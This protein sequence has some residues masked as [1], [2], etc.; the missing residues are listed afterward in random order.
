[1]KQRQSKVSKWRLYQ[2]RRPRCENSGTISHRIIAGKQF[3]IRFLPLNPDFVREPL[4]RVRKQP[5]LLLLRW[6]IIVNIEVHGRHSERCHHL[7]AGWNDCCMLR[8]ARSPTTLVRYP[9]Y[10]WQVNVPSSREKEGT[11]PCSVDRRLAKTPR[12]YSEFVLTP[13][14]LKFS[15]RRA[16]TKRLITRRGGFCADASV[17]GSVNRRSRQRG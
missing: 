11:A 12:R 10:V 1:M 2:H 16:T 15:D 6:P 9:E 14:S 13:T 8:T 17:A 7:R 5:N 3:A 4:A